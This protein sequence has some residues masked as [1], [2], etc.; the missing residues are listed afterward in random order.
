MKA[1]NVTVR[2]FPQQID[3]LQRAA[4]RAGKSLSDYCRETLV[5]QAA[6]DLG[7]PTLPIMPK[8][9]RHNSALEQLIRLVRR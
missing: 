2:F 4:D 7:E 5:R 8:R 6:Q 3:Q 1:K 9:G